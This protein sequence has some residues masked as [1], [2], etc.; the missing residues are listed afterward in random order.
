MNNHNFVNWA[1][2]AVPLVVG[3]TTFLL[4]GQ[5]LERSSV[6]AGTF[7]MSAVVSAMAAAFVSVELKWK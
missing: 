5:P 6:L 2:I 7:L 3:M 4:S 1:I